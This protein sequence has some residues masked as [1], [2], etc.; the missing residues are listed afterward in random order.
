MPCH[1]PWATDRCQ[2]SGITWLLLPGALCPIRWG[3]G[4]GLTATSL[5]Q[6]LATLEASFC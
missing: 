6:G 4:P 5:S 1:E 2:T 3:T